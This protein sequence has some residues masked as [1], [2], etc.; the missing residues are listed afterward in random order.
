MEGPMGVEK[1]LHV[2]PRGASLSG[3]IMNT[4]VDRMTALDTSI[5]RPWHDRHMHRTATVVGVEG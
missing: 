3:N 1:V 2:I 5:Y 4:G